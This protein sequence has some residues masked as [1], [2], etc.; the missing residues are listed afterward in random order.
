MVQCI[1]NVII[2]ILCL[3][4]P[5]SFG[6]SKIFERAENDQSNRNE[7]GE[8]SFESIPVLHYEAIL[9]SDIP[10][11][12]RRQLA[13][14]EFQGSSNSRSKRKQFNNKRYQNTTS[15]MSNISYSIIPE[16]TIEE[17]VSLDTFRR[18]EVPYNSKYHLSI[19]SIMSPKPNLTLQRA[20]D[21]DKNL[22]LHLCLGGGE[23]YGASWLVTKP[24]LLRGK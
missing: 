20:V 18:G 10:K 16:I 7:I 8:L 23:A 24:Y 14:D 3:L 15:F 19:P 21:E 13:N 5:T 17:L 2:I 9:A 12:S 1:L 22:K 6:V 11:L 4:S